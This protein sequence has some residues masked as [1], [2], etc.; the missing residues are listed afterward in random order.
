MDSNDLEYVGFWPR[1]GAALID[2]LVLLVLLIPA[3]YLVYGWEY[4]LDE[5]LIKG[6]ADVLISWVLPAVA[7]IWLW[8]KLRAT[9]GKMLVGAEVVD[10]TT[11]E[12]ISLKQA[13][14][15]YLGYFVSTIPLCLG[16]FWVAFDPRKQG[17]HDKIAGT[18][19]VRR[20]GGRTQPVTFKDQR[21]G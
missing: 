17:W 11:G 6:P 2:S 18:V 13:I 5:A 8:V 19:V 1:V 3:I 16:I 14:I 4:F 21:L 10:A 12:T 7:C 15:R 20:K 9:P